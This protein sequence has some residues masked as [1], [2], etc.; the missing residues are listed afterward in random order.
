M[1]EGVQS[2]V[3]VS[4][5]WPEEAGEAAASRPPKS[6]SEPINEACSFDF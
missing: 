2:R 3:G 4:G 6:T 1:G 5:A